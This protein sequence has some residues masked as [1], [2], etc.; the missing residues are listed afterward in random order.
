MLSRF[1]Y[2]KVSHMVRI[3]SCKIIALVPPSHYEVVASTI[4]LG[5]GI[6]PYS[7]IFVKKK[8]KKGGKFFL[9]LLVTHMSKM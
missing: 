9:L 5:T 6:W 2:S 8:R 4:F 1:N 7:K 3:R